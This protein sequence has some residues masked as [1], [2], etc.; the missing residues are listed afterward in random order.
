MFLDC[1]TY[2]I[3]Y[4]SDITAESNIDGKNVFKKRSIHLI[5]LNAN[6]LLTGIKKLV[7][8]L[9]WQIVP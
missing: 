9:N 2:W 3:D 6:N 1:S 7:N 5:N 8:L 4:H